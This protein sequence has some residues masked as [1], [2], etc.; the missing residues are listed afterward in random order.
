MESSEIPITPEGYKAGLD[1]ILE[2]TQNP[3]K[4]KEFLECSKGPHS[5]F[6]KFGAVDV[7]YI[8]NKSTYEA[9]I[10]DRRPDDCFEKVIVNFTNLKHN[11]INTVEVEVIAMGR[12]KQFC[13]ET[14]VFATGAKFHVHNFVLRNRHKFTW[15]NMK[16]N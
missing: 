13:T 11:N 4:Q 10:L 7:G 6:F 3:T 9:I 16:E 15:K 12:R 2:V 1:T 8:G 5:E 14:Y